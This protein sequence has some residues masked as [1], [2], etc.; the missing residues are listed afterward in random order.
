MRRRFCVIWAAAVAPLAACLVMP[1]TASRYISQ[2]EWKAP[3]RAARK[4]N[5]V[6]AD[7]QSIAAGRAVYLANCLAC[8]GETGK[9]DGPAA[10]ALD[11]KPN[12]LA[13]PKVWEQ[14]DGAIFWKITR[15]RAPMPAYKNLLTDQERWN[16]LNYMRTFAPNKGLVTPPQFE[17]PQKY[18]KPL[19]ALL[20]PYADIHAAIVKDDLSAARRHAQTFAT[21]LSELKQVKTDEFGAKISARWNDSLQVVS[22][23]LEMLIVSKDIVLMR[24]RF[25]DFSNALIEAFGRFGHT[26]KVPMR[27]FASETEYGGKPALW[28]QDDRE[29]VNPYGGPDRRRQGTLKKLLGAHRQKNTNGGA[30]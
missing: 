13:D 10:A 16:V 26:E 29:P 28:L 14:S 9:G 17:V 5:P 27:V 6:P 8:H 1:A 7:E 25:A 15:G 11:P 22:G 20:R 19:S 23:K 18:R 2:D 30:T 12:D 21:A 24:Q 4:K 3:G